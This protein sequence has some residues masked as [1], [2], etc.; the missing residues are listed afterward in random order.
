MTDTVI[1]DT[2][3]LVALIN[4][5]DAHHEWALAKFQS[6]PWPAISCEAV[7]CEAS[8]L[9]ERMQPGN[10]AVH[11]LSFV[12]SERLSLPFNLENEAARIAGMMAKYA[13]V[14]MDFADAC[15]VR[16]AETTPGSI[17]LTLDSDFFIYRDK[18]GRPLPLIHPNLD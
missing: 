17:V 2:G 3:P 13:S 15:L 1:L 4:R 6:I 9:L 14:P 7:I 12:A 11:V 16:L 18:Q 10:G 5:D 8:Y